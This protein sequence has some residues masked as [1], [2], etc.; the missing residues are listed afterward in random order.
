LL[1]NTVPFTVSLPLLFLCCL[2][3]PFPLP[4]LSTLPSQGSF[5]TALLVLLT[6]AVVIVIAMA[7]T[8]PATAR[9]SGIHPDLIIIIIVD[10]IIPIQRSKGYE[11]A[12]LVL[13]AAWWLNL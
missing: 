13:P 5:L 2:P 1:N 12:W 9:V 8:A 11:V 10:Y 4:I 6:L 7:R 3:L